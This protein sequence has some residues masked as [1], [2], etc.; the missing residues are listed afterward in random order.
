MR[1]HRV[2]EASHPGPRTRNRHEGDHTARQTRR[3]EEVFVHSDRGRQVEHDL[4]GNPEVPAT[5]V[6][7]ALG[8]FPEMDLGVRWPVVVHTILS[9]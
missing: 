7:P 1:A 8:F 2:G 4:V 9:R 6:D 5:E 3:S